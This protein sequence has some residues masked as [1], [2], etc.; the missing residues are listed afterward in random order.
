[1]ALVTDRAHGGRGPMTA[2]RRG[3][4]AAAPRHARRGRRRRAALR[5]ARRGGQP[6]RRVVEARPAARLDAEGPDAERA[7]A[8]AQR[9]RALG[10]RAA[11]TCACSRRSRRTSGWLGHEAGAGRGAALA[12]SPAGRRPAGARRAAGRARALGRGPWTFA[13]GGLVVE[14][15]VRPR[16]ERPPRCWRATRCPR[17]ALRA[18]VPMAEP[19]LSG[20]AEE[21]AFAA[22]ACRGAVGGDRAARPDVAAARAG[23][24]RPRRVRRRVDRR[25]AARRR[26]VRDG[27]GRALPPA[28]RRA[29]RRAAGHGAAGAGQSSWGPAV[30]GV[31]GDEAAGRELAR[32]MEVVAGGEG[33]VELVS[34]DNRGAARRR[35][36]IAGRGPA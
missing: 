34:F 4:G 25:P 35:A 31:V 23:R 1:M 14:G 5:R 7:L 10:S 8:V 29:G 22:P 16:A 20:P 15:G 6:A 26:R 13:L 24:A 11:R 30:Y 32:P 27:A 33:S 17:M 12:R 18:R 19:G 9:C 21:E 3:A 2:A 36:R 28:R